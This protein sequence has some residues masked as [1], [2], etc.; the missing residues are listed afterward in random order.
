MNKKSRNML[1][2]GEPPLG[3]WHWVCVTTLPS[4]FR[5]YPRGGGGGPPPPS[6]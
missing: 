4:L 3:Q 5:G 2:T 6:G 1:K